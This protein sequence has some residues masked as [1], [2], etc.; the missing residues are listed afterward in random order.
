MTKNYDSNLQ[1]T[2]FGNQ[3]VSEN[4]FTSLDGL[5]QQ[6]TD[7]DPLDKLQRLFN[8][9]SVLSKPV[10]TVAGLFRA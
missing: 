7:R 5:M 3:L 6:Q 2:F 1:T 9:F 10:F 4:L 8:A